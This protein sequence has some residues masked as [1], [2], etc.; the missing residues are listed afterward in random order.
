VPMVS[1]IIL[2]ICLISSSI[3]FIHAISG[4]SSSIK[5]PNRNDQYDITSVILQSSKTRPFDF[6]GNLIYEHK[7]RVVRGGGEVKKAP[8]LSASKQKKQTIVIAALGVALTYQLYFHHKHILSYIPTK[9]Q[10]Q[11]YV[12]QVVSKIHQKGN[13]GIVYYVLLLAFSEC[14]G[15]TTMPVE[16]AGGMLYGFSTGVR[17]NAI[18]KVGGKFN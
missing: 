18:G 10:I 3:P 12:L 5:S 2:R 16:I 6:G 8:Q 14:V 11:S 9:D 1:I 7:N 13:L 4:R 15:L 17:L